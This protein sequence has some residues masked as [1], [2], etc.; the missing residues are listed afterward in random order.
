M[1]SG[2]DNASKQLNAP[3]AASKY[4]LLAELGHGG[5]ADL[6]LAVSQGPAGFSKLLVIKR[7]RD[8]DDPHF[9][10][11]FLD[12]ARLA[13]RLSHP[14]IV[15]T[16]EV[17]QEEILEGLDTG[18][19]AAFIVMEFLEGPTLQRLRRRAGER[20]GVPAAIELEIMCN[21]L[22]GLHHAHELRGYDG[23]PLNVV[24]RDLSPQNVIVTQQGECKVLDFGIAKTSDSSSQTE[25][26]LYKGKLK[27]MPPEQLRGEPIDRR[28]DIFAA[29][30]MLW[31]GLSGQ[32]LWDD[33][34]GPTV[35]HRLI[36][37]DIPPLGQLP[38]G[39]PPELR[40]I[41]ARALAPNAADRFASA[42]EL[43]AELMAVIHRHGLLVFR[44]ELAAFVE[45]FYGAERERLRLI[46]EAQLTAG[47]ERST[48]GGPPLPLP[49]ADGSTGAGQTDHKSLL[50]ETVAA[51]LPRAR[52]ARPWRTTAV[53]AG[54]VA[55]LSLGA[56][57][58]VRFLDAPP[59]PARTA[60]IP[61]APRVVAIGP[62]ITTL[63]PAE[64]STPPPPV[65]AP[66]ALEPRPRP[67][68]PRPARSAAWHA[69][70]DGSPA[71]PGNRRR[72]DVDS[73]YGSSPDA[74][75]AARAPRGRR[76]IDRDIPWQDRAGSAPP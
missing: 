35:A 60:L 12:E 43:K 29:G 3:R 75:A 62:S 47:P 19:G 51:K 1:W 56:L 7:L 64:P 50:P 45:E 40:D 58:A 46:I 33:L 70:V 24:H 54:A 38:A 20:G 21:V 55:L 39:V 68:R 32:T 4:R 31:E 26:G 65:I 15:Q 69:G 53:A 61:Q 41:C 59:A 23:R 14:N 36:Q 28:G 76:D 74:A 71:A 63:A 66:G 6:Y 73:P 72:V 22:E 27:N 10:T 37:G 8:V 11:M 52:A 42:I 9:V 25:A 44:P 49:R 34:A 30:V 5:M 18:A 16:Y 48:L 2:S 67:V 13:A 17:G 57:E